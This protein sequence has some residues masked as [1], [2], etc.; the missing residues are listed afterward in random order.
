MALSQSLDQWKVSLTMAAIL[1]EIWR[2][3]NS[4]LHSNSSTTLTNSIQLVRRYVQDFIEV[5]SLSSP[6]LF[7]HV[8]P[9]WSPPPPRWIKIN[10][11]AALSS[12]KVAIAVVARD[13]C[14]SLC[15]VWARLI[16]L[17]SPL[18]AEAEALLW[19]MQIAKREGWQQVLFEGDS[20]ICF[21]AVSSTNSPPNWAIQST[22]SNVLDCA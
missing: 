8:S 22:I 18:Q 17:R 6:P 16:S 10:V 20:K 19:A 21:D 15:N 1:E 14:G 12:S 9:R 4:K 7:P 5:S 2:L 3:R 13:F 11:D